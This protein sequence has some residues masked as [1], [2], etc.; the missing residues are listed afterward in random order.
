[1]FKAGDLAVVNKNAKK[2]L[3]DDVGKIGVVEVFPDSVNYD[4][5]LLLS[6][7]EFIKVRHNELSKLNN[8][9]WCDVYYHATN[10]KVT[11]GQPDLINHQVSI[12]FPEG[13]VKV[14]PFND[15]RLYEKE[16]VDVEEQ[17]KLG[18]FGER[19][20]S[21]GKLVDLKQESYGDSV[22]KASKLMKIYL[23]DYKTEDGKYILTEELIDHIL[24]QVRIIDKQ[25]RIF[26]NPK[27]DKMGES[28]YTDIS[29]YGLLGERIQNK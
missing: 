20:L 3:P 24:L 5:Q 15:V 12:K 2:G 9:N 19:G 7:G 11:I 8:Y 25:N 4:Y 26:S 1:M 18:Y 22:S 23:E 28:P 10:E 14:V 17:S 21:L 29:G 16:S 27:A 13:G 6:N